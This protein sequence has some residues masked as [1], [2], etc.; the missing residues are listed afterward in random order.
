LKFP[1]KLNFYH[2]SGTPKRKAQKRSKVNTVYVGVVADGSQMPFYI[3]LHSNPSSEIKFDRSES[4]AV[5][6]IKGTKRGERSMMQYLEWAKSKKYISVGD[7]LLMD[8]ERA[9][10]TEEI[11]FW[12][13]Q[14]EIQ[15][16][17][18]PPYLGAIMNP[19]DNSFNASFKENYYA[20]L[21]NL[22]DIDERKKV[23]L[24]EEAYYHTADQ[25]IIKMFQHVGIVDTPPAKAATTLVS[26]GRLLRA[27]NLAVHRSQISH[28][29]SWSKRTG[30]DLKQFQV[31]SLNNMPRRK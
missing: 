3:E 25:G 27:D 10:K 26:E 1:L 24:A 2:F 30:F 14:N 21:A 28:F 4:T 9:L 23:M 18:F 7:L 15:V 5:L 13:E 11:Q 31:R 22:G 6:A 20:R 19:C 12:L 29:L 8:N 16:K 17:Y